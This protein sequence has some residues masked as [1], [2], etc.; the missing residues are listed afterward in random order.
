MESHFRL[1]MERL[2][3]EVG[4]V[5]YNQ[6]NANLPDEMQMRVGIPHRGGKL[7]AHAF[8][9]GY[10]TMV[11]ANA[12]FNPKT[13]RFDVP[14]YS[15]LSD[16][17]WALDSAGFVAMQT[18]K[19][20]GAQAGVGGLYPWSYADYLELAALLRPTWFS[21]MDLCCEPEA[22][23]GGIHTEWRIRATATM[24]EGMLQILECWQAEYART[25]SALTVANDLKPPVPIIQG[26][27]LDDYLYS[28]DLTM[29]VWNR[30]AWLAPPTLM[31]LGSVCRRDLNHPKYGLFAILNGLEGRLPTGTKLHMFG[32]KGIAL[33]RVRMYD[34][35]ASAD[36]MAWDVTA[37]RRAFQSGVSNTMAHRA[38]VMSEWMQAA[39]ARMRPQ[40][41]DQFRL[42]FDAA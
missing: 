6:V 39:E 21:A 15:P 34:F 13:G 8:N 28:L 36:S 26:W 4:V 40:P 16:L 35:V 10:P 38:L 31:G 7:A 27:E 20:K 23:D 14:T 30:H 22:T 9:E 25:A 12:F 42:S 1:F 11:S 33:D 5:P 17:D 29:E 19:A 41:G 37:R 32:I 18:F 3:G 2:L 24:L